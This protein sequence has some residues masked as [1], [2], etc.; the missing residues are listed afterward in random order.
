MKLTLSPGKF[1]NILQQGYS[2]DSVILLKMMGE[3]YDI[4]KEEEKIALLLSSL[5]RKVLITEEGKITEQGKQLLEFLDSKETKKFTKLKPDEKDSF[6]IWWDTYPAGATFIYRGK[7]FEG[8]RS[9]RVKRDNCR[10][11]YNKILLEG[12]ATPEELLEALKLQI[13]RIKEESYYTSKNTMKY[14]VNT[15]RYFNDKQYSSFLKELREG[16][17]V[18]EKEETI[19]NGVDI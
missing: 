19:F 12:E 11:K 3:G 15:E 9:F 4:P 13:H 1:L 16:T 17:K 10:L 18:I 8:T 7:K 2:F 6:S 14:L 5:K